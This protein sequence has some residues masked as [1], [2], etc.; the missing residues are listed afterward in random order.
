M[1]LDKASLKNGIEALLADMETRTED[2]KADFASGLADLIDVFVKSGTV[3]T[4]VSTTVSTTGSATAQTGTG[5]G[6][7]TGSIS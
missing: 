2:A 5:E 4:E 7:G 1:A 3:S 6:T